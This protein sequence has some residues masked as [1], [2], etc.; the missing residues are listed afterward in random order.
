MRNIIGRHCGVCAILTAWY[1]YQDYLFYILS[2][3]RS[4]K[5]DVDV[6]DQSINQSIKTNLYSA[7][8]RR[9]IRGARSVLTWLS[10]RS[11]AGE[12][13]D[14]GECRRQA[15]SLSLARS[16]VCVCEQAFCEPTKRS[17]GQCRRRR[18]PITILSLSECSLEWRRDD[19]TD[20]LH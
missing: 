3:Q 13:D 15:A 14:V 5:A 17:V 8:R 11:P 19:T 4:S 2:L 1:K 12:E 9:R 18:R 7:L 6:G 10:A 20:W 16:S